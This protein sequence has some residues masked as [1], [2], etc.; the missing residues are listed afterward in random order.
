MRSIGF[1]WRNKHIL[2]KFKNQGYPLFNVKF[3]PGIF[4]TLIL[5]ASLHQK[6]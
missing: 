5:N 3:L 1:Y 6:V 2:F 4:V